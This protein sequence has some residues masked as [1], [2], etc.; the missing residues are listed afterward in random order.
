MKRALR[1]FVLLLCA[2][3]AGL[4]AGEIF[5]RATWS[6][7]AI[8]QVF[9]RGRFL[10]LVDGRAIHERDL[11][12]P[13][14]ARAETTLVA[15]A[16]RQS[17]QGAPILADKAEGEINLLHAQFA[18]EKI[19]AAALESA[20]LTEPSLRALVEDHLAVRRWIEEQIAPEV[21][22]TDKASREIYDN[23]PARFELPPRFRAS[24]LFI[25]A[26][27]G[28]PPELV[29]A[30]RGVAQG[31]SVRLLAGESLD[32]LAAEASEDEATKEQGGDL[33]YFS[34]GRMP[35]DFMAE[36]EKLSVGQTSPPLRCR[37]GFHIV[38]LTEIKPARK[39]SFEEARAEIAAQILNQKRGAAVAAL[40]NM[41]RR[42]EWARARFL[43]P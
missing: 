35:P 42:P 33:N 1:N 25:A 2:G 5:Y 9:G 37:L 29:L 6:R 34:A 19:F 12:Q 8:G 14:D 32:E 10:V 11:F 20:H 31:L 23:N 41:I 24:H 43:R 36:L 27:E 22:L 26:P 21:K 3:A 13:G 4:G 28:T 38:A 39:L 18:D 30:K 16:L 17:P 7:D 40:A 15:E